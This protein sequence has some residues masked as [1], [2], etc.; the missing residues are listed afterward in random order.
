M[1]DKYY[2]LEIKVA[3]LE[4]YIEQMN[5]VMIDQ[6]KKIDRLIQINKEF[7]EKLSLIEEGMKETRDNTPPPHY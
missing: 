1:D 6:G 4:D 2:D 3:Y 5:S 7:N